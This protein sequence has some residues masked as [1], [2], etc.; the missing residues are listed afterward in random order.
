M[1]RGLPPT[2]AIAALMDKVTPRSLPYLV[3]STAGVD[4]RAVLNMGLVSPILPDDELD[5]QGVKLVE[6]IAAQ[7]ADAVKAVKVYLRFA[8][9][10]EPR[11]RADFTASLFAS[12]LSSR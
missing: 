5:G 4:S 2:L 6:S 7:P 10:M 9:H 8:P 12:V 3:Y 11:G 1:G